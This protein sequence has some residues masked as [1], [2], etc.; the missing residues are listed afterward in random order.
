MI[1]VLRFGL[2]ENKPCSP[3]V[4]KYPDCESRLSF[5]GEVE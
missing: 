2:R 1:I 5:R 4:E 3:L